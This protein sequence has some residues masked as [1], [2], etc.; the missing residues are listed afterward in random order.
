MA[1]P[2]Y[3]AGMGTVLLQQFFMK[4]V[5]EMLCFSSS[6]RLMKKFVQNPNDCH[7]VL[8]YPTTVGNVVHQ[9]YSTFAGRQMI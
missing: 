8:V 1:P 4:R 7:I 9:N 5:A 2:K 3:A 6:F